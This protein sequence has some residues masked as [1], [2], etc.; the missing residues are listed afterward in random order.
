MKPKIKAIILSLLL[1]LVA[2]AYAQNNPEDTA[3]VGSYS[4]EDAIDDHYEVVSYEIKDTTVIDLANVMGETPENPEDIIGKS[5]TLTYTFTNTTAQPLLIAKVVA[6]CGCI[7]TDF[8]TTQINVSGTTVIQIKFEA[9][10]NGPI[11]IPLTIYARDTDN[12]FL[13]VVKPIVL[14]KN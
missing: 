7:K 10:Q 4:I 3:T 11:K 5:Y 9:M 6:G 1:L 14:I 13:K 8:A 2:N 12:R